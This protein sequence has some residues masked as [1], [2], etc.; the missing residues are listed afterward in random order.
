MTFQ[1]LQQQIRVDNDAI[2]ALRIEQ[3]AEAITGFVRKMFLPKQ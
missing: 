2:H 3:S 1:I